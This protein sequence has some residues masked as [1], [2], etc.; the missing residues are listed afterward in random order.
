MNGFPAI[1]AL[2]Q[3]DCYGAQDLRF[4]ITTTWEREHHW[5][6]DII[7]ASLGNYIIIASLGNDIIIAVEGEALLLTNLHC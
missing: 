2:V 3:L 4:G 1:L 6:N 7:I 5:G